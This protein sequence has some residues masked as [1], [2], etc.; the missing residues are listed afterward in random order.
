M[1]PSKDSKKLTLEKL[2][3]KSNDVEVGDNK[4][5]TEKLLVGYELVNPELW[6]KLHLNIHI[7]YLRTDGNMRAGGYVKSVVHPEDL[8]GKDTIKIELSSSLAPN[9]KTWSIYKN[10]IDKLWKRTNM[11]APTIVDYSGEIAN[12]K[13]NNEYLRKDLENTKR[14]LQQVKNDLQRTI[15]L[16]KKLHANSIKS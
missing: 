15:N 11:A 12:N 16:I 4:L 2:V 13:K 7:R 1:A 5:D 6:D 9:S 14:E 8:E 10:N 3:G